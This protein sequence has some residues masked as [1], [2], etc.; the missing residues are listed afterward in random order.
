VTIQAHR[1]EPLERLT[2]WL[3]LVGGGAVLLALAL[4]LGVLSA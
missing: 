4:L 2:Y 1:T 3:T